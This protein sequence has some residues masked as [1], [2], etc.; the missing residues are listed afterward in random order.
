MNWI[1]WT[2]EM[3][4]PVGK[5]VLLVYK[6]GYHGCIEFFVSE[7]AKDMYIAGMEFHE[8]NP[9]ADLGPIGNMIKELDKDPIMYWMH[10]PDLPEDIVEVLK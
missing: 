7:S 10:F 5:K 4:P 6:S 2:K 8:E 1:K 3:L 9:N